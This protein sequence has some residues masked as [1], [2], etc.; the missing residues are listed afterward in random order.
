MADDNSKLET[1]TTG[2]T[3]LPA[4]GYSAP[5][6]TQFGQRIL[7]SFKRDPQS[8]I[9]DENGSHNQ[10]DLENGAQNVPEPPLQ[11]RLK[12]RHV[13]MIAIGGSIGMK[14]KMSPIINATN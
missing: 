10:S 7:D 13:Q 6:R 8:F 5:V 3:I 4:E 2:D 14:S 12:A 11:R 1:N 9:K